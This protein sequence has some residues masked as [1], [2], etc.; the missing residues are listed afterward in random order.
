MTGQDVRGRVL[1]LTES[2]YRVWRQR[3][4]GAGPDA[5]ALAIHRALAYM[6]T[7]LEAF[8]RHDLFRPG[9]A[10]P[11]ADWSDVPL[12]AKPDEPPVEGDI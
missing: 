10:N 11:W 9:E 4:D 6:G 8:R 2:C 5:D 3:L 7:I 12:P 1:E